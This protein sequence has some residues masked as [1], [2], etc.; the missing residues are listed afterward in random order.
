MKPKAWQRL[1]DA[2]AFIGILIPVA[3][4]GGWV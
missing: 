1:I 4:V 3:I 2:L